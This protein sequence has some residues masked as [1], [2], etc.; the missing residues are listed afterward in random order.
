MRRS[1]A[2]LAS[3]LVARASRGA[4]CALG[5]DPVTGARS[6]VV[7][8][9][10]RPRPAGDALAT[11]S[12]WREVDAEDGTGR[13]YFWNQRSGE[14]TAVGAPRPTTDRLVD[15]HTPQLQPQFVPQTLTGSL[16]A[17]AAWGAGITLSFAA[18]RALFG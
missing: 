8:R 14:T 5:L 18:V 9:P 12:V 6:L 7:R 11:Q 2:T 15:T 13:T 1:A 10:P 17:A 3:R 16:L 4:P